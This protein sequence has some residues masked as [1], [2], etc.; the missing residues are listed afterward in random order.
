MPGWKPDIDLAEGIKR[1]VEWL[2]G[3]LDPP[4]DSPRSERQI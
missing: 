3:V 1:T 4:P 2:R